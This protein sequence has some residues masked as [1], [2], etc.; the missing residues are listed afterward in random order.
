MSESK[1][2]DEEKAKKD[3]L[4]MRGKRDRL[5][6]QQEYHG[7]KGLAACFTQTASP[8]GCLNNFI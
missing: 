8:F 4:G 6:E 2:S 5:P 3:T 7:K 1:H